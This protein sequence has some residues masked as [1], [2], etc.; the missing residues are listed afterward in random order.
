MYLILPSFVLPILFFC[1]CLNWD[2]LFF[3]I[4][5]SPLFEVCALFHYF[6]I[7]KDCDKITT[8]ILIKILYARIFITLYL[9][10]SHPMYMSFWLYILLLC[11]LIFYQLLFC[12]FSSQNYL[13]H[14]NCLF[15]H[16]P[17]HIWLPIWVHFSFTLGIQCICLMKIYWCQL[18]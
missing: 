3:I 6:L 18:S 14:I 12:T 10:N 15:F 1:F 16:S 13:F 9:K 8:H 7:M 4:H 5:P 2:W 17:L 11:T